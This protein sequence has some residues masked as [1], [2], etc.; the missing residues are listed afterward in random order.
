VS[1]STLLRVIA[2]LFVLGI[3][4]ACAAEPVTLRIGYLRGPEPLSISRLR[5][6][7]E[8]RLALKN[9]RVWCGPDRSTPMHLRR[10]R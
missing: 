3:G 6:T 10:R 2:G 9:I 7:L 1:L 8:Q 5:G 4:A